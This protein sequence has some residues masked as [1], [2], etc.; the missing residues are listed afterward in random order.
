RCRDCFRICE[1]CLSCQ[2][3]VHIRN[4]LHWVEIWRGEFFA[5][6]SLQQL[7]LIIYL[8]HNGNPCPSA[9]TDDNIAFT[10]LHSNGVHEVT[11]SFCRCASARERYL[12][13]IDAKLFPATF[14]NPKTAITFTMLEEYSLDT[15]CSKKSAFDRAAMAIRQ[16]NEVVPAAASDRYRELLRISRIWMDLTAA[17]RSGEAHELQ[18]HL[19]KFA[20]D[21][22]RSPLCPAC[23]QLGI[24]LSAEELL[25]VDSEKLHL[26][27]L[28]VGGDG[29][30]SL[31]AK[32]KTV[33]VNDVA[34]N[35]G[36]GFFPVQKHFEQ[37]IQTHEDLQLV[38]LAQ[39]QT[40]SGF[41][42]SML[43]QGNLGYRSSGIYSWSC[44]RHGLYRP[45]GT[46]DLQIGERFSNVDYAFAGA[47]AG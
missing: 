26:Y 28:Y 21:R 18:S 42:T 39:P 37:Y 44:L 14:E 45:G 12:Q 15:R 35:N 40:C 46:V 17:R 22:I 23:P 32:K 8:G 16:T 24:N 27:A 1:L 43:F 38:E 2:V 19:P 33:D 20:A 29:N 13:L 9:P 6:T 5:R 3:D 30:F 36:K 41:K 10:V 4:P 7:G 31:S 47:I 25:N 11:L 34:L